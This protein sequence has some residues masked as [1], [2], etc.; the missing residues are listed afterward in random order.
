[1]R[2]VLGAWPNVVDSMSQAVASCPANRSASGHSEGP[3]TSILP[4]SLSRRVE[5]QWG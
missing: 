4:E 2:G 1:M 3:A 5:G